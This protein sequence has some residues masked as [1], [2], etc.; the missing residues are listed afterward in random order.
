M[1]TLLVAGPRFANGQ[2]PSGSPVDKINAEAAKSEITVQHLRRNV[3]VL[4][5][6]GGNIAVL[7]T[8]SGKLMVDAGIG[9]SRPRLSRALDGLGSG[10]VKFVIDT[11]WHW[12]HTDGNAWLHE[13]GATVVAHENTL[14]RLSETVRV[15]DWNHTFPP[16]PLGARP[17]VVV[18]TDKN[19]DFDDETAELH[20]YG[21]SHTD[22]DLY[23][24]FRKADVLVTGDTFWNG[25]YP[26]IDTA[27]GG[28]ID[29]MIRAA[30]ANIARVSDSTLVISGHG[31]VG[32]R[33]DLIEF[34]D[35]LT[36]IRENV[37]NQKRQGKSAEQ[38]VAAK[39]TAAYDAKWGHFV[40]D[41]A[42]FT[43]LV[44]KSL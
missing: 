43:R 19:I 18:E 14:R 32:R 9:M 11:H 28:S 5:G 21:L 30:N 23:V 4:M 37:A 36:K 13:L 26:F 20:Y 16:A 35:M 17:T 3:S 31:P 8:T 29:G 39:P 15:E 41:P 7:T 27:T 38:T 34:R 42:F 24:Y 33:A 25:V 22:S 44:Y 2:K 6:S 12:D 40:I 10:P 1:T